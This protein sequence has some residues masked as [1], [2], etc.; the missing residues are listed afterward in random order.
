[1][2][3]ARSAGRYSASCLKGEPHPTNKPFVK[4][5]SGGEGGGVRDER[6]GGWTGGGGG[7]EVFLGCS[8]QWTQVGLLG[9]CHRPPS[10]LISTGLSSICRCVVVFVFPMAKSFERF[11]RPQVAAVTPRDWLDFPWSR[12][13]CWNCG[14]VQ[15]RFFRVGDED[16]PMIWKRCYLFEFLNFCAPRSSKG[17][18][19][20]KKL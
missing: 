12:A 2:H 7:E 18:L 14:I 1:M 19:K 16:F 5:T 4:R 6:R 11:R 9:L 15:F 10:A 17:K 20:K 8:S 13:G 3:Q